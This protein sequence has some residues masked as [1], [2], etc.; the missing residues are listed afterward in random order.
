MDLGIFG[1]VA[2]FENSSD[3][4]PEKLPIDRIGHDPHVGAPLDGFLEFSN[5]RIRGFVIKEGFR[6]LIHDLLEFLMGKAELL[7]AIVQQLHPPVIR[8]E[9]DLF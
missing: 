4:E 8:I 5:Q 2:G 6:G 7:D 3:T 1:R 9:L